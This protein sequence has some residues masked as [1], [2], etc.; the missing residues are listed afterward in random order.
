MSKEIQ[1]TEWAKL[2]RAIPV[3]ARLMLLGLIFTCF[4]VV[5]DFFRLVAKPGPLTPGED[6]YIHVALLILV[7][8]ATLGMFLAAFGYAYYQACKQNKK[9][10]FWEAWK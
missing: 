3:I 8:I 1:P 7:P 4:L 5:S 2:W 9:A 10:P 6:L